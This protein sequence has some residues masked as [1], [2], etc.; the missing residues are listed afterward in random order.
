MWRELK[1]PIGGCRVLDPDLG[2]RYLMTEAF[3]GISPD[4]GHTVFRTQ[5]DNRAAPE[6][7]L[8]RDTAASCL[9]P[10]L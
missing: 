7:C 9:E 1:Q 5:A 10:L 2:E 4:N 6:R 3:G 8:S